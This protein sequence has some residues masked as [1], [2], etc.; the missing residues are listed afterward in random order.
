MTLVLR[1]FRLRSRRKGAGH[2]RSIFQRAFHRTRSSFRE[3]PCPVQQRRTQQNEP[4]PDNY[5]FRHTKSCCSGKAKE[6]WGATDLD[7]IYCRKILCQDPPKSRSCFWMISEGKKSQRRTYSNPLCSDK[8]S[9]DRVT[10][11]HVVRHNVR[12]REIQSMAHA[13][14]PAN[15]HCNLGAD[16]RNGSRIISHFNGR[17]SGEIMSPH[18][19]GRNYRVVVLDQGIFFLS[20]YVQMLQHQLVWKRGLPTNAT[21]TR[22]QG[23]VTT[24]FV[25]FG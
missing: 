14:R 2:P 22:W 9:R 25:R 18:R 20:Q 6:N 19:L 23:T 16:A 8:N 1:H 13:A 21:G 15:T 4:R 17:W 12:S 7:G 3:E 10:S 11:D 5:R 24:Y